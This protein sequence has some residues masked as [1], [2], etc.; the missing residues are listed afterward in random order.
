MVRTSGLIYCKKLSGIL[1]YVRSLHRLGTA[2]RKRPEVFRLPDRS[3]TW[4]LYRCDDRYDTECGSARD[5]LQ[6]IVVPDGGE[7]VTAETI[8]SRGEQ[9]VPSGE[10]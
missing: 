10:L 5:H 7:P 4:A 1:Q 2:S 8:G 6:K 3:E 9:A